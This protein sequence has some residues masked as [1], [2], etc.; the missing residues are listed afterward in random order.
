[1]KKKLTILFVLLGTVL[2]TE[3]L[4]AQNPIPSYDVPIINDPTVFEEVSPDLNTSSIYFGHMVYYLSTMEEKKL[5]LE[6]SDRDS[7]TTSWLSIEVYSLDG[8]V[9]Y[10]PFTVNEGVTFEISLS[11]AL[12]WGVRVIDASVGSEVDVWFD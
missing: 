9:E 4:F 12:T 8:T 1:M 3:N 2:L 10:G 6:V 11:T 5:K 7:S